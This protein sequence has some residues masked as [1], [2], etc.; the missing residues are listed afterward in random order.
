M[1][2]GFAS[3]L[4]GVPRRA[5]KQ[6]PL[7]LWQSMQE[8]LHTR[9]QAEV[10]QLLSENARIR[11]QWQVDVLLPEPQLQGPDLLLTPACP[12]ASRCQA[13]V[14]LHAPPLYQ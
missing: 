2:L 7:H 5:L 1:R 12:G 4:L 8:H 14:Y 13:L 9:Q 3:L 6:Y 10:M 11:A